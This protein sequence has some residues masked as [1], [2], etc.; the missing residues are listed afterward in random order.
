M[1][2]LKFNLKLI[3]LVAILRFDVSLN[4]RKRKIGE[5]KF[6]V[7][8]SLWLGVRRTKVKGKSDS[9]KRN[10]AFGGGVSTDNTDSVPSRTSNKK[11]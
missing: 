5:T 8:L 1:P 10:F 4:E 9:R 3:K 2:D 11:A 7:K 6:L